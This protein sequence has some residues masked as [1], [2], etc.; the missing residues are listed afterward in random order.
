MGFFILP[1]MLILEE[2]YYNAADKQK[3]LVLGSRLLVASDRNYKENKF[4][5]RTKLIEAGDWRTVESFLNANGTAFF[6]LPVGASI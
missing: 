5:I 1:Y 3:V 6:K 4:M 2:V